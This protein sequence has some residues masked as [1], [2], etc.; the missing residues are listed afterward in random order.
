MKS[1]PHIFLLLALCF[2]ISFA[3]LTPPFQSPDEYNHFYRSWQ[4]SE[5]HFSPEQIDGN[6]LGGVLPASLD[7]LKN[8]FSYLKNDYAARTSGQKIRH[9]LSLLAEP[10]RRT[11]LDFPNTAIYAPTAYVPQATGILVSRL[12]TDRVLI[13]F[14]AARLGNLA[15]WI[16]LL[17]YA[18]RRMPFQQSGFGYL[19]LLPSSLFLSATCNAD[20]VT[21]GLSFWVIALACRVTAM[22]REKLSFT[23]CEKTAFL[24][25]AATTAVNKLILVPFGALAVLPALKHG[26]TA[27]RKSA[28]PLGIMLTL[29][30]IWG[31]L[32]NS[33]FIPYDCYAP[34]WRDAQTL[35]PGVNPSAQMDYILCHP[36]YFAAT[37]VKSLF[38]SAPSLAAHVVGKFGWEKNYLPAWTLALLW[39]AMALLAFS[40]KNLLLAPQ[41]LWLA[42]IGFV[43]VLLWAVTMYALWC[44]VGSGSLDNWQGRYFVPVLPL[45][46]L[47]LCTGRLTQWRKAIR[48]IALGSIVAGNIILT[49]SI[50]D[51]Y[52]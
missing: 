33:W 48:F 15:V 52:F 32:A 9:A 34:E 6:R 16:A 10:G 35:N 30:V 23:A 3:L 31:R 5:G 40:E 18:L 29:A 24:L 42:A 39:L 8:Q 27:L 46:Y 17:F 51:R 26:R 25:A 20:I 21:N 38:H 19:A 43:S 11:F 36:F 7:S 44:P 12:F 14:Y 41:R 2:G 28:L 49:I 22:G 47:S 4:V 45:I 37:V 13:H 50:L 1:I